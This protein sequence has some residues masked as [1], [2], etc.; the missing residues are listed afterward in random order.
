MRVGNR[1]LGL[2]LRNP[3]MLYVIERKRPVRTLRGWA[4]ATLRYAGAIRECEHHGWLVDCAD[5]L[6][7]MPSQEP[8]RTAEA[9]RRI[10]PELIRLHRYESRAV[11]RRDKA[12]RAIALRRRSL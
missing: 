12:I 6:P 7:E 11:T 3:L 5:P 1:A 2:I 4:I 8:E 9:L 10:L